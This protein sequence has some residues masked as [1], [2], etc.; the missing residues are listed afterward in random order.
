MHSPGITV[1]AIVT[2][3]NRARLL[4]RA[5]GSVLGQTRPVTEIIVV[6][7]GSTD[8]TR[9][10]VAG[11]GPCVKYIYQ[12]SRGASAARNAGV[13]A[14]SCEWVA[15]LDDDDE[16][17]P[18]K[19]ARQIA[20]IQGCAGAALCYGAHLLVHA[21]GVE[22]SFYPPHSPDTVW[23]SMRLSAI[24]PPSTLMVRRDIYWEVGGF[25]EKFRRAEDWDFLVRASYGRPVAGVYNEPVT[26]NYEQP[27][28]M[29][30][31]GDAMLKAELE[32]VESVLIGLR[33]LSR[34]VWRRRIVSR[35]YHRAAIAARRSGASGRRYIFR[36]LLYWPSPWFYSRR[37]GTAAVELLNLAG[38]HR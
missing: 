26:R 2:T 34:A 15:F 5:I 22:T 38:G 18:E 36:S 9:E 6:D 23:P 13:R 8:N 11:Y 30:A 32:V 37:F 28:S 3:H 29:S 35:I 17:L 16:W 10:V 20:A 7:D 31:N 14:T 33:G 27:D 19:T 21:E 24:A 12:G 4:Q 25:N 1:A